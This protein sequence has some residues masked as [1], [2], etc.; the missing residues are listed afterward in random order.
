M[1]AIIAVAA[2]SIVHI[3]YGSPLTEIGPIAVLDHIFDLAFALGLTIITLVLGG[4]LS[5]RLRLTFANTAEGLSFS[6]F[7]GTGL[8]G[9]VVLFLGLLGLLHI[10]II[11]ALSIIC[12]VFGKRILT[13]FFEA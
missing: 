7:L 2:L 10:W 8:L 6:L 11:A 5:K 12:A 1:T 9:L 13:E 4:A 3:R